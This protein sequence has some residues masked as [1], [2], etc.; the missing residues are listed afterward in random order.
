MKK[1]FL[2]V[3]ALAIQSNGASAADNVWERVVNPDSKGLVI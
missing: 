3:I 2:I 1:L